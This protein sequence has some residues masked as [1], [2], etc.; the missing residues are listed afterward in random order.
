[1]ATRS[2]PAARSGVIGVGKVGWP[3]VRS[4]LSA[5][6]RVIAFDPDTTASQR[7]RAVGAELAESAEQL[8]GLELDVLSPCAVGGL[9]DDEVARQLRC[10]IVCGCANNQLATD[11]TARVLAERGILYV[12]DFLANCGGLI[13]ADAERRGAGPDEVKLR[14]ADAKQRLRAVLL[15]ARQAGRIPEIVAEDTR[16]GADRSFAYAAS[17]DPPVVKTPRPRTRDSPTRRFRR[18]H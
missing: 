16:L 12:P 3:I 10:R 8:L 5:G 11:E 14:V 1:M 13:H 2:S 4:L 6:A 18:A 9:I 7:A 15:E 17:S